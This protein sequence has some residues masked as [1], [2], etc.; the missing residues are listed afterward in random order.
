IFDPFVLSLAPFT[1]VGTVK[2]TSQTEAI[3]YQK[4][5][6]SFPNVTTVRLKEV[7]ENVRVLLLQIKGA[8]DVMASI[9]IV[10]GIL[11][12]SGAIA[13]GHKGRVYDSAVLKIVGATRLDILKAYIFE[14]IILGVATGAVAIILGSIAAYGIVVGIMELQWTFSFQIPLLTIVAAIILTMSIGMFS[15][16]KAMSVRP[17]QVLRGV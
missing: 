16:Y 5:T 4:I 12:L 17:A 8:I 9:T 10:S 6:S 11:V 2:S 7:L 13:A 14:F 15:I 3:N 1:Y